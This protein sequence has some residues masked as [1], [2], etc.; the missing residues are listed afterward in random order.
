MW[1]ALEDVLKEV[2]EVM[3]YNL[4]KVILSQLSEKGKDHKQ[5][6]CDEE[7]E[8]ILETLMK[9]TGGSEIKMYLKNVSG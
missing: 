6:T 9:G 8:R 4:Y 7:V 2:T 5:K 3:E 1:S